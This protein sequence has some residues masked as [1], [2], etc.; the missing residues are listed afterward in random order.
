MLKSNA[1]IFCAVLFS[2]QLTACSSSSSTSTPAHTS[3]DGGSSEAGSDAAGEAD[4]SKW[5]GTWVGT[6]TQEPVQATDWQLTV[7]LSD[8]S[9]NECGTASLP[10]YSCGGIVTCDGFDNGQLSADLGWVGGTCVPTAHYT[11]VMPDP[12]HLSFTCTFAGGTCAGT[13]ARQ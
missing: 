8:I 7:V 13:L 1:V 6:A 12:T 5:D 4:P 3:T 2:A 10:T 11:F 9:K